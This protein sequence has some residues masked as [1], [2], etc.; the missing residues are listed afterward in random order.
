MFVPNSCGGCCPW[1]CLVGLF[2]WLIV[3]MHLHQHL[4]LGLR[5]FLLGL[6]CSL[7]SFHHAILPRLLSTFTTLTSSLRLCSF[8][9]LHHSCGRL[10]SFCVNHLWL[11]LA[12]WMRSLLYFSF[13]RNWCFDFW[14]LYLGFCFVSSIN[15]F[16]QLISANKFASAVAEWTNFF[17]LNVSFL[18]S[19]ASP[20]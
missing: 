18:F 9:R 10:H 7:G 20:L 2:A 16:F 8:E 13:V 15:M 14:L 11:F 6:S 17:L 1:P 12:C 4:L 5:N 3:T 19:K